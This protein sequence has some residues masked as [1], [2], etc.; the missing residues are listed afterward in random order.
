MHKIKLFQAS[1]D[2]ADAVCVLRYKIIEK[3]PFRM[4]IKRGEPSAADATP[5]AEHDPDV[6]ATA[7]N[8]IYLMSNSAGKGVD[9][10]YFKWDREFDKHGK[11]NT[12]WGID[13]AAG[14]DSLLVLA[15]VITA[16]P[17]GMGNATGINVFVP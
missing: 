11:R 1:N 12:E 2:A 8:D 16:G 10:K 5:G 6:V 14:V 17:N 13:C 3:M 4:L 7:A 15:V 9:G